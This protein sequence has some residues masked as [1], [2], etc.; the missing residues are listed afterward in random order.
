VII[1][2]AL[3]NSLTNDYPPQNLP[4]SKLVV[5]HALNPEGLRNAVSDRSG[6]TEQRILRRHT[7][8]ILSGKPLHHDPTANTM[9][10]A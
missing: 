4:L 9:A 5:G 8:P 2:L 10:L 3:G 6:S 1:K 7:V